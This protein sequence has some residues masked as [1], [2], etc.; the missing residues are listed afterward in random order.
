MKL[1]LKVFHCIPAIFLLTGLALLSTQPFYA[2]AEG[3]QTLPSGS[4]TINT[5]DIA[6][7]NDAAPAGYLAASFAGS[8]F[9]VVPERKAKKLY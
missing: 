9:Y 1:R 8:G 4:S 3:D 6:E 7:S 5:A 2:L